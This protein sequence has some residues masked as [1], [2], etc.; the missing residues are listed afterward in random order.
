L[1]NCGGLDLV[2]IGVN[3]MRDILGFTIIVA[4]LLVALLG[5]FDVL[6]Y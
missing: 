6:Y 3:N 1:L 4:V 2:S 5:F